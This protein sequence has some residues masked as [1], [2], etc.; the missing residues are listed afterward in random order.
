MTM[1]MHE[2]GFEAS[3]G[4]I[5]RWLVETIADATPHGFYRAVDADGH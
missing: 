2:C 1:S 4:A 3:K 5:R